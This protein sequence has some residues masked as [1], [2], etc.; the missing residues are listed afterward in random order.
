MPPLIFSYLCIRTGKVKYQRP[1][2]TFRSARPRSY[3]TSTTRI[4][5]TV[6][7]LFSGGWL[8][9]RPKCLELSSQCD[10]LVTASV[11]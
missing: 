3:A 8:R 7:T 4:N 11:V 1:N 6:L 10:E 9:N 5:N 2:S